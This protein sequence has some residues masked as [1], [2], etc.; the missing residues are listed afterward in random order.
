[1]S[2]PAVLTFVTVPIEEARAANRQECEHYLRLA[3]VVYDQLAPRISVLREAGRSVRVETPSQARSAAY[4]AFGSAGE[5]AL[6]Y[7]HAYWQQLKHQYGPA[8]TQE[9]LEYQ[10]DEK[11]RGEAE[12]RRRHEREQLARAEHQAATAD[13]NR[14]MS[15]NFDIRSYEVQPVGEAIET[16]EQREARL[17]ERIRIYLRELGDAQLEQSLSDAVQRAQQDRLVS[18]ELLSRESSD[19][20]ANR[21]RENALASELQ[22]VHFEDERDELIGRLELLDDALLQL[23]VDGEAL[24]ETLST[25]RQ[26][27]IGS[28]DDVRYVEAQATFLES[29]QKRLYASRR[30]FEVVQQEFEKRG[31]KRTVAM[32]T[33]TPDDIRA[34]G[35]KQILFASKKDPDVFVEITVIQ[36]SAQ[37]QVVLAKESVGSSATQRNLK[38]QKE[39]CDAVSRIQEK[40]TQSSPGSSVKIHQLVEPDAKPP[41]REGLRTVA[42]A[43][44][45]QQQ[46]ARSMSK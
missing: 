5:D 25:L 34:R 44:P 11:L 33:L 12:Q 28:L 42:R 24:R 35:G 15:G 3:Q 8:I 38:Y 9:F 27:A 18:L 14:A 31:Y 20:V 6:R 26:H 43:K 13:V 39:L 10:Y 17:I 19:R 37:M 4:A 29:E 30:M 2:S 41:I 22:R 40:L 23:G 7:A 21:R 16:R 46:A 45:I 36:N 32:Q 1:M